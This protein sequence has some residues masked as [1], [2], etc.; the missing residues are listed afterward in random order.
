MRKL[1]IVGILILAVGGF[2]LIWIEIG[3][4]EISQE[5]EKCNGPVVNDCPGMGIPAIF[6]IIV[7][8]LIP[9]GMFIWTVS[10]IVN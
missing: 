2:F 3:T 10:E 4:V 5:Y 7:L 6:I 9:L 1:S 8:T